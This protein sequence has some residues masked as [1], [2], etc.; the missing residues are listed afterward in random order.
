MRVAKENGTTTL[1]RIGAARFFFFGVRRPRILGQDAYGNAGRLHPGG[2]LAGRFSHGVSIAQR[3]LQR[4]LEFDRQL[5]Q[6]GQRLLLHQRQQDLGEPDAARALRHARVT[7][8]TRQQAVA[9]EHF[10]QHAGAHHGDHA[11]RRVVHHLPVGACPGTHATLN[12]GENLLA[13]GIPGRVSNVTS[14]V[15]MG[16][17]R[18]ASRMGAAGLR[19]SKLALS[20]GWLGGTRLPETAGMTVWRFSR[21]ER[22]FVSPRERE[23]VTA[24]GY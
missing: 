9:G 18:A 23:P 12:A 6:V 5:G 3:A 21:I 8:D 7:G 10:V 16:Y 14:H 20:R 13:L 24:T 15:P 2:P 19:G 1:T 22:G 11:T 17:L 4:L